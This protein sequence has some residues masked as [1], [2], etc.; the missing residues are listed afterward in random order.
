MDFGAGIGT[1]S[2]LVIKNTSANLTAIEN[3][4]FCVEQFSKHMLPSKRINL[5]KEIPRNNHFDLVIIDSAIQ[6]RHIFRLLKGS[7]Q[8]IIFIEGK[9]SSTVA[10]LS[11]FSIFFRLTRRFQY[12]ES[13]LNLFGSNEIEKGGSYFYFAKGTLLK[14]ISTWVSQLRK[15]GELNEMRIFVFKIWLKLK[16]KFIYKQL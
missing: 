5:L 13:R 14:T 9:R 3:N 16:N 10:R 8:I 4:Q 7:K 12:C 6:T 1:L 15:T 11:F 2:N